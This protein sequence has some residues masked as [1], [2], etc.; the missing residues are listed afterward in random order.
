MV[1]KGK[2]IPTTFPISSNIMALK[3]HVEQTTNA[4]VNV[5]KVMKELLEIYRS[6]AG[7]DFTITK[8]LIE[9]EKE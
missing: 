2:F 7:E 8:S 9:K 1:L 6:Y 4:K 3:R 5:S